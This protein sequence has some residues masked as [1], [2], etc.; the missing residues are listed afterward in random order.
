MSKPLAVIIEDQAFISEMYADA[1]TLTGLATHIIADGKTAIVELETLT[2]TL[3]VLDMNLPQVSGHYL[4]KHIRSHSRL[5]HVPI[6]ISTANSILAG[7]VA[8]DLGDLD[9]LML[10]PVNIKE[11]QT[12]AKKL[13]AEMT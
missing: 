9:F 5:K 10:K 13:M 1:L 4:Y 11:L 6:I 3:I 2:P 12:L 7:A 8:K